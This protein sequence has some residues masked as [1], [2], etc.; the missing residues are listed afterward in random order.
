[1]AAPRLAPARSPGPPKRPTPPGAPLAQARPMVEELALRAAQTAVLPFAQLTF[2]RYVVSWHHE[3]IAA[4]LEDVER[5]KIRRLMIFT[6][7]RHGKSELTSI[8]FP[9]WYLGRHPERD[10]IA[11]S[12][13]A[14]LATDF[15]RKVRNLTDSSMGRRIFPTCLLTPDSHAAGRWNT[16][17]GGAYVAAGVGGAITGRGAHLL[18]IDDPVKLQEA[19]SSVVHQRVWDW[20]QTAAYSRLAPEGAVVLMMTRTRTDD[21]AGRLLAEAATGGEAW[22]VIRLP[23]LAEEEEPHRRRGEALW[24]ERYSTADLGGIQR[25]VGSRVWASVWQQRPIEEKGNIMRLAWWRYHSFTPEAFR[26]L[27]YSLD[28]AFKTGEETSYSV[29][30][31]WGEDGQGYYLLDQWREREEF[32]ELKRYL[33]ARADRDRPH[34]I[35]IEDKASG[36]S[37]IQELQRETTLPVLPVPVDRDK[38]ARATAVTPLIEAGRVFLPEQAPWLAD[39]LEE[40]GA[41]PTGAHDDQVD[42]LTQALAYL[43]DRGVG[44]ERGIQMGGTRVMGARDPW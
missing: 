32:P 35:L 8:R 18:L 38:V 17:T 1:M 9:A 23:A 31:V 3:T 40:M 29:L 16:T 34:A 44:S 5:G 22:T 33:V 20:Y 14:E 10:V 15:G 11:T 43:R 4:A 19:D 7:P 25:T 27:M 37:L 2:P 28:T 24:P 21:L 41:F 42:A 30:Q 12:Y 36:T 6:P 39:F 13:G 26:F